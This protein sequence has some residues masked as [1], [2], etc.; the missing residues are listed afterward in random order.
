MNKKPTI[1]Y[2]PGVWDFLHAG[3]CL[4]LEEAKQHCDYLVVGLG[5]NPQIGNPTK[6]IPIMSLEERY[7]MLRANKFV[8]AI[9]VYGTE[10]ESK[11]IDT[12]FPYDVR[13]LGEDHKKEDLLHIKKPMYF[14][15]RDHNYSSSNIRKRI[16]TH[17]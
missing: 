11:A 8:D 17:F 2:F 13:F 9:V 16:C 6:N 12:W 7:R 10:Y 3:H 5:E 15:K 14:T 1:G 4:A